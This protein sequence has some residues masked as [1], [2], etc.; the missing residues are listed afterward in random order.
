MIMPTYLTF[1][2]LILALR[3]ARTYA[4]L[5]IPS[6]DLPSFDPN[7]GIDI[8][9][10]LSSI[11]AEVAGIE[12]EVSEVVASATSLASYC[13][14]R[15]ASATASGGKYSATGVCSGVYVSN[16]NG[17]IVEIN[18]SNG[19][20]AGQGD[21][22]GYNAQNVVV[23]AADGGT[24]VVEAVLAGVTF[25]TTLTGTQTVTVVQQVTG[26]LVEVVVAEGTNTRTS[27]ATARTTGG[28]SVN[29]S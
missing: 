8:D 17:S 19:Q 9:S 10:L 3:F 20:G 28:G 16:E 12:T 21:D 23:A 2:A 26:S 5:L 29:I 25:I 4:Q 15:S 1:L 13:Q 18:E 14:A 24:R 6:L 22:S 11:T 27:T 7:I